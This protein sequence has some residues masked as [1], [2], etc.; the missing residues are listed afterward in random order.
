MSKSIRSNPELY[1]L[2]G[3]TDFIDLLAVKIGYL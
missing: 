1:Q 3:L 2:I